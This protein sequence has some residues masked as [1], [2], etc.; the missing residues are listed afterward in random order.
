V[1]LLD[2]PRDGSVV[3]LVSGATPIDEAVAALP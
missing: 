2:A 1:A 3:E